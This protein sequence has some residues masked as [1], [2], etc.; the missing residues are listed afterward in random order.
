MTGHDDE[1][2]GTGGTD[3]SDQLQP[4]DTLDDRGVDDILDEGIVTRERWSPGQG[5]GNTAEEELRGETLDQRI[6]QEEPDEDA[7]DWDDEDLDDAQVG[8]ERSGR[9]VAPDEG[10]TRTTSRH[11]RVRR[12][13]RRRGGERRG[14]RDAR[15][16][17]G[18]LL[19]VRPHDAVPRPERNGDEVTTSSAVDALLARARAGLDRVEP[20]DLAAEVEAGAVVVDIRPV[21]Q[22]TSD[23]EIPGAVVVNRNVLEWRLDPTSPHRLPIP[24]ARATGGRRVPRGLPVQPGRGDTARAR[25]AAR[26]RPGRRAPGMA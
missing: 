18:R 16:V 20:A 24:R 19:S 17:G 13:H 4:G 2:S 8:D 11:R 10:A 9:L 6:A 14:G 26:H 15:R 21:E 25:G 23:G 12:R 5:F 22:R 1:T 7:D 3:E